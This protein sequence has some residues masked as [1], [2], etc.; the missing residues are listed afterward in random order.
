M[1]L[2]FYFILAVAT[3]SYDWAGVCRVNS[4]WYYCIQ[5]DEEI[6]VYGA[7]GDLY[8]VF[9]GNELVWEAPTAIRES[10]KEI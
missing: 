10:L 9:K 2:L 3:P 5:K 6:R 1:A 8:W 7:T 4:S